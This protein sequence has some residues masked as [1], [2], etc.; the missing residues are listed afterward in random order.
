MN[1]V[2]KERKFKMKKDEISQR[3]LYRSSLM[4]SGFSADVVEQL[5]SHLEN[6]GD[7]QDF[8]SYLCSELRLEVTE[9]LSM[10]WIVSKLKK[11]AEG[12][13]PV[14]SVSAL[15]QLIRISPFISL[16]KT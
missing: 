9:A 8:C 6:D 14:A 1:E 5:T 7:V 2:I 3:E 4:A 12:N 10:F 15:T 11:I 16:F 13:D